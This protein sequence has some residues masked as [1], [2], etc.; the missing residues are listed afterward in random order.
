MS[1]MSY[2]RFQNTYNDLRDCLDALREEPLEELSESERNAAAN[3]ASL[4]SRYKRVHSAAVV[5]YAM[6][7]DVPEDVQ[8]QP[9]MG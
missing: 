4:L 7:D 2:C 9:Q 6:G 8:S 1:N 3:I 5:D